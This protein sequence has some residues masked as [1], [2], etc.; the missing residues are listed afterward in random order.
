MFSVFCLQALCF[1]EGWE[2][3][4]KTLIGKFSG[5]LFTVSFRKKRNS[6]FIFVIPNLFFSLSKN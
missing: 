6:S 2:A 4:E 1:S 5:E 3:R